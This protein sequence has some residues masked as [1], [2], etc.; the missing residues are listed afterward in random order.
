MTQSERLKKTLKNS[1]YRKP[2]TN[3]TPHGIV[4]KMDPIDPS[5]Q[6]WCCSPMDDL[7]LSGTEK[8]TG[9]DHNPS[10]CSVI[11]LIPRNTEPPPDGRPIEFVTATDFP[12]IMS[13][14]TGTPDIME[15]LF[16]EPER[17]VTAAAVTPS[18]PGQKR[19]GPRS[20]ARRKKYK[21][22]TCESWTS[23]NT[24]QEPKSCTASCNA[25]QTGHLQWTRVDREI[26]VH[27]YET[28]ESADGDA[29]TA[30]RELIGADDQQK[31]STSISS[32]NNNKRRRRSAT[33]TS[34]TKRNG[35]MMVHDT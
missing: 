19:P 32:S 14:R 10:P 26:V 31:H 20:T 6:P 13:S 27:P 34:G 9:G 2:C 4:G 22:S 1:C 30:K 18:P 11:I 24:Q 8:S 12:P 29:T 28:K 21:I 25:S 35:V 3:R 15:Y 16:G 33:A 7:M 17:R 5:R 23:T